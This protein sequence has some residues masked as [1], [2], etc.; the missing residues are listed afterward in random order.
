MYRAGTRIRMM[1][2]EKR[3]PKPSEIAIGMRNFACRDVS[4][5]IGIR[6]KKVVRVV[7]RIG[8][9]RWIPALMT[10]EKWLYSSFTLLFAKLMRT[11]ESLTTTPE[12]ATIP[13]ILRMLKS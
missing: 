5:I 4:K 9:K 6:P 2:V 11:R 10:A 3:M 7:R 1:K 12:R 13:N 8:R